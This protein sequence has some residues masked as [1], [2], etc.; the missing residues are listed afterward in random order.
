MISNTVYGTRK[1]A[2][3]PTM[4]CFAFRTTHSITLDPTRRNPLTLL[5]CLPVEPQ[6][7]RSLSEPILGKVTYQKLAPLLP[8]FL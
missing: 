6:S 5:P 8:L 3:G 4:W 1:P 7:K 2:D